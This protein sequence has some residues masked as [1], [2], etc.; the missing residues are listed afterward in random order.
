MA[1]AHLIHG[2]LGSGKTTFARRL[3]NEL[4]ALRFTH[5]EWMT[6]L[7]EDDPA[8]NDFAIFFSRV[9]AHIDRLW[10]RCLALGVDIV[11]DLNFWSR[12]QRDEARAT[13]DA[14]G[15]ATRLYRLC[16][17]DET[18]R[19]VERCIKILT[20]TCSLIVGPLRA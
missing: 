20:E 15:A 11:P 10:L 16:P 6:R 1:T 13:A 17:E 12:R 19:R 5:D 8:I 4:P 9:S 2:F 3:E 7:Y 14:A 18:W